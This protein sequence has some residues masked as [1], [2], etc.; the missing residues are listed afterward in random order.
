[1]DDLGKY[2]LCNNPT[3]FSI[4][5]LN[6]LPSGLVFRNNASKG[7]INGQNLIWLG[8]DNFP[9]ARAGFSHLSSCANWTGIQFRL[10]GLSCEL[11]DT[12]DKLVGLLDSLV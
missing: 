3:S 11:R 7:E 1:M 5:T 4:E 8:G 10:Y 2:I 9:L 6:I 12:L